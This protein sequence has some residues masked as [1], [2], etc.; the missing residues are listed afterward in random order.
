MTDTRY[1]E[2]SAAAYLVRVEALRDVLVIAENSEL[3][4]PD[5]CGWSL[6]PNDVH[7]L[8]KSAVAGQLGTVAGDRD[9][10]RAMMAAW[11]AAFEGTVVERPNKDYVVLEAQFYMG[12]TLVYV[13]DHLYPDSECP[14]CG[15]PAV[16]GQVLQHRAD[17]PCT[18]AAAALAAGG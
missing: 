15:G 11:A 13:W 5:V 7:H 6:K 16:G 1:P 4:L 17:S 3:A 18:T 8:H 12:D 10:R 2:N 14:G 9:K